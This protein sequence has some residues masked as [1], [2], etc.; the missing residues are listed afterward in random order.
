MAADGLLK[1]A[2]VGTP[3]FD[4]LVGRR[5]REPLTIGTEFDRGNGLC[6]AGQGEFERIIGSN[7]TLGVP[8]FHF[9]A[10]PESLRRRTSQ[11]SLIRNSGQGREQEQ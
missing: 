11:K 6:V 7:G 10:G 8:V 9:R 2:V 1:L 4:E 5:A 3:D